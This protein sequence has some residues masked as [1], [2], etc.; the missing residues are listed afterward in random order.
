MARPKRHYAPDPH[1]EGDPVLAAFMREHKVPAPVER[2][3]YIDLFATALRHGENPKMDI[4]KKVAQLMCGH[5][6]LTRNM[7]K[8]PCTVCHKMILNGEDYAKYR[9]PNGVPD[10]E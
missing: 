5:R 3:D 4:R 10:M 7:T 9:F 6:V 8:A 2:I 1:S